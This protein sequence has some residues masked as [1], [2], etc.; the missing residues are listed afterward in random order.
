MELEICYMKIF[1]ND[2]DS[3][4]KCYLTEDLNLQQ[5]HSDGTTK[6]VNQ[7]I[8]T[9][10]AIYCHSHLETWKRSILALEFTHNN[11]R[12]ADQPKTPFELIMGESSKAIPRVF[13]NTRFPL[14]NEKIKQIMADQEEALAAHELARNQIV[15]QRKNM[16]TL[17]ENGQKAG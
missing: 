2:L 13:K 5:K 16:F 4:I 12:H 8:K 3:P 11:R 9:Y 10:L 15:E 17:F 6:W 7:E 14:I 1:I